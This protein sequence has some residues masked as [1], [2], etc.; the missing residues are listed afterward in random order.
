MKAF[1]V[2]VVLAVA[3]LH[4]DVWFWHDKRLV[5]GF[6]PVGLAYHVA[7]AFLCAATLGLLVRFAW[8]AHL[9]DDEPPK[10]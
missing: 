3:L 8:P 5:F 9:R 10:P 2:V 6:L 1:L 4:Q 7:Y